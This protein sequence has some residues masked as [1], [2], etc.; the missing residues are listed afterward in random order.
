M[1]FQLFKI[2]IW[3]NARLEL[4]RMTTVEYKGVIFGSTQI[5]G[6]RIVGIGVSINLVT[7]II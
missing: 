3:E 1:L 4:W 7:E 5:I 6:V 2:K